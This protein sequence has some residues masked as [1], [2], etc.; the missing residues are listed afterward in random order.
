MRQLEKQQKK[1]AAKGIEM[2]LA[3]L[4]DEWM[5][6]HSDDLEEIDVVGDDDGD[7]SSDNCLTPNPDRPV[8]EDRKNDVVSTWHNLPPLSSDLPS[9][10]IS[11]SSSSS[12][13]DTLSAP[14]LSLQPHSNNDPQPFPL[15]AN[16]MQSKPNR[17]RSS[18][19]IDSLLSTVQRQ[20]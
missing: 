19:S 2:D 1:L 15:M 18:F 7:D 8:M 14:S 11:T 9:P 12:L 17:K 5:K 10:V 13:T 3:S 20:H 6:K 16:L 4:R